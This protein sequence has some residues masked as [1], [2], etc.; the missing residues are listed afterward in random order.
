MTLNLPTTLV[1]LVVSL[2]PVTAN[3]LV[4]AQ[5]GSDASD[6]GRQN[7]STE[8]M[9]YDELWHG[10]KQRDLNYL[11]ASK[12]FRL[13]AKR[14]GEVEAMTHLIEGMSDADDP[15][16]RYAA[17]V[18]LPFTA[19]IHP[20]RQAQAAVPLLSN[21]DENIRR[22]AEKVLFA[23]EYRALGDTPVFDF[24]EHYLYDQN[25]ARPPDVFVDRLYNRSALASLELFTDFYG[26]PRRDPE[27]MTLR[28]R[29]D[30]LRKTFEYHLWMMEEGDV[31]TGESLEHQSKAKGALEGLAG[32]DRWWADIFVAEAMANFKDLRYPEIAREL[33]REDDLVE[34]RLEWLRRVE[35]RERE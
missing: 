34:R 28:P 23:A 13:L 5:H 17:Y 11:D 9:S 29:A 22:A 8:L 26:D 3:H 15:M 2:M 14:D 12:A 33:D 18:V 31:D 6:N 32:L 16:S 1:F 25:G 21:H 24:Y 4:L 10:L 35:E 7:G 30:R 19:R 27:G 20:G